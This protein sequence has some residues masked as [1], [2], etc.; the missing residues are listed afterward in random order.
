MS[1]DWARWVYA[2]IVKYYKA[3]SQEIGVPLY[4]EGNDQ[5]TS[6]LQEYFELRISGPNVKAQSKGDYLLHVDINLLVSVSKS[7][8]NSFRVHEIGGLLQSKVVDIPVYMIGSDEDD[9]GE[10]LV[11]CLKLRQEYPIKW[12][13]LGRT[14]SAT[15]VL[16]GVVDSRYKSEVST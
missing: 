1:P 14:E 4:V 3:V 15:G 7:I 8:P 9:D 5:F 6:T 12:V 16:Q 2:S 10:T 11:F 13:Y